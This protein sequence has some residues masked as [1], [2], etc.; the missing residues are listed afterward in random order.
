[1]PDWDMTADVVIA[2]SGGAAL[3]AALAARHHGLDV[4]VAE[5]TDL[6]GGSTAMSGGGVWIPDSPPMRAAGSPDSEKDALAYFQAVVGDA[7]AE[8]PATSAERRQAFIRTGPR[9][10]AFLT[11]QGIPFRYAEGYSDYYCDRPGGKDR[12]RTLE[13]HPFDTNRLGPWKGKLRP[14]SSAGLGLIGY[15]TEL[16]RMSYYNRSLIDLLTGVKVLARTYGGKLR[17]Q[18]LTSNGG[19]L[20]GRLLEQALARG[21]Q[22]WTQAPVTDLIMTGDRVTGAIVSRSTAGKDGKELRV[23]ARRAVLLA[24]GGFARSE[25]LRQTHGGDQATTAAWT[26]ASPGDTGEVMELAIKLGAATDLL[27]EAIWGPG[28]RMP[29]GSPPKPYGGKR[30]NAFSRARWRPGTIIVD[31]AGSRF[32][33]EAV[34]YMEVGKTMFAHDQVSP[35]VPAWLIFDDSYRR[36]SLFGI[37]PGDLPRKWIDDGFILKA[38]SLAELAAQ[39]GISPEGLEATVRRFNSHARAGKDPDFGRGDRAYDWFMGDPR[40]GALA[41]LDTG[42]YYASAQYPGDFGTC[43][44]LLTDERARVLTEAGE[45]IGG[46]Y[47]AGNASATVMGR[48]Y[49]GAGASISPALVFGY[50][51]ATG[52]AG[53]SSDQ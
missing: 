4:L 14:G 35:S 41:P 20:A 1:M 16:T 11:S 39:A 9:V 32:V 5:K 28:P 12:G 36:R 45:P 25:E 43:G 22:V 44:G 37:V 26:F 31:A 30:L 53:A 21:V 33:N 6:I 8:G 3:T 29:D 46:L 48:H 47:A 38:D 15:G 17:G 13:A 10:I 51:A 2:G 18:A 42:P 40:L 19:A 7:G 52:I 27:D 50:I 23:R 49:L 34:S 24:A